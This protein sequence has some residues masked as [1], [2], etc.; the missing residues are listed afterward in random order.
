MPRRPGKWQALVWAPGFDGNSFGE[1]Y[2]GTIKLGGQ[3][4][5]TPTSW[6]ASAAPGDEVNAEFTIANDGPTDLSAYA[7]SQ[8]SWE[9]VPRYDDI[10]LTPAT[11]EL[12]P[13]SDG[14]Q[15][16]LGFTLPQ[17]TVLVTAAA[18]W[19]GPSTLVDLGLYDPVG[20]DKA[21]SLA[22]TDLGNS[23]I[24]AGSDGRRMV[25]H[26]G[27]RQPGPVPPATVDY[28]VT[29]DYVTATPITGLTSSATFDAPVTVPAGDHATIDATIDVPADAS[30]GDTITG[31]LDFY[32]AG[33]QV[34]T[35]GG[36][37]LGSIPVTITVEPK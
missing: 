3:G 37:H 23:V 21:D 26:R 29:V 14:F 31:T 27:L 22:K 18:T 33:D 32:T 16:V 28:T 15:Q 8:A 35:A 5:V 2:A 24:V 25:C 36:D 17:R 11:G 12:A 6:T 9:G 13:T 19:T 34:E 30:P 10:Q 7:D 20:T 4:L 1:P